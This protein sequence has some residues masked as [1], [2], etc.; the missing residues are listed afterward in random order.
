MANQE[1]GVP[2]PIG[3]FQWLNYHHLYYFWV[4][5][6]EGSIARASTKLRLGQ[7][8]LSTQLRLLEDSLGQVLFD[9]R[10]RRLILTE[11]GKVALQYASEIFRMGS[12][13]VEALHD[14]APRGEKTHLQI[15]ALDSV[16]KHITLR[17]TEAAYAAGPCTVSILEGRGDELLRELQAHR[18]DVLLSNFPPSLD[19][20]GSLTVR[21][22]GRLPIS[23]YG[24]PKYRGLIK[25]FPESLN[26]QNFVLPTYHSKLRHDLDH[27][28]KTTKTSIVRVAETQDSSL[29]KLLGASGVGLIPI[30]ETSAAE[31]VRDKSLIRIG[32][33]ENVSEDFWLITSARRVENPIAASLSKSFRLV[34]E[35]KTSRSRSSI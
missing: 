29:Q 3:A 26:G 18:L 21:S 28:F 4:I 5:A 20:R 1:T 12:E 22:I 6:T 8:T 35:P 13:M 23:V 10:N 14:R 17:L 27:Y 30:A 7:P 25:K 11:A 32:R 31:L 19:E 24:A 16:S 2:S 9:R 33:L 34:D 15:G